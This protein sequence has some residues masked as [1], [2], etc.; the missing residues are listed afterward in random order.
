[1][2]KTNPLA[3]GLKVVSSPKVAEPE[4][5]AA[6]ASPGVAKTRAGAKMVGFFLPE[7]A[8]KALRMIAVEQGTT[9]QELLTDAAD[10]IFAK[11]GKPQI[12]KRRS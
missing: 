8:A 6:T 1:M 7:D 5:G 12:A 3:E 2:A 10:T 9:L 4:P 11:Y